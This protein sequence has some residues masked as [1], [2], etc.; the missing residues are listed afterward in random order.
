MDMPSVIGE[1]P[2]IDYKSGSG[3]WPETWM[4][5]AAYLNLIKENRLDIDITDGCHILRLGKNGGEFSH[6]HIPLDHPGLVLAWEQFQ[7]LICCYDRDKRLKKL[8]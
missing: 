4:Q 7:A 1:L 8:T 6:L 5:V 3:I 2:L